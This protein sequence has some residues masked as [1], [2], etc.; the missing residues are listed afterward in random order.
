MRFV[1]CSLEFWASSG[2]E[3]KSKH[4]L[5]IIDWVPTLIH[6]PGADASSISVWTRGNVAALTSSRKNELKVFRERLEN[7]LVRAQEEIDR[8]YA[9]R[10]HLACVGC[11]AFGSKQVLINLQASD[12]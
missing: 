5:D 12:S 11:A 9:V 3:S 8:L 6:T 10:C 2:D 7:M 4:S 1:K